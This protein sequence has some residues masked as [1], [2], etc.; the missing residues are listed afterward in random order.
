[1]KILRPVKEVAVF[2]A[3][4]ELLGDGSVVDPDGEE[5][6]LNEVDT[7]SLEATGF[8]LA[9]YFGLPHAAVVKGIERHAQR[10]SSERER[11]GGLVEL[12]KV[13]VWALPGTIPLWSYAS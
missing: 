1:M 6:N 2:D 3:E 10:P 5:W 12:L 8:A 13:S 4:F 9:G 7:F 11:E